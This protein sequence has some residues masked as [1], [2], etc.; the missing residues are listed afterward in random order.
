MSIQQISGSMIQSSSISASKIISSKISG[1]KISSVI[2]DI[3]R[4]EYENDIISFEQ[5]NIWNNSVK[6]C[7]VHGVHEWSSMFTM[8]GKTDSFGNLF[9]A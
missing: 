4:K 5:Y 3:D 6:N 9:T 1:S 8:I 7:V 2:I